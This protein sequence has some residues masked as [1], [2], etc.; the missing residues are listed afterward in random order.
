MNY[1]PGYEL[2]MAAG[3]KR[4][5]NSQK[6]LQSVYSEVLCEYFIVKLQKS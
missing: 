1:G 6:Y 2:S 5:Q 3:N 4:D